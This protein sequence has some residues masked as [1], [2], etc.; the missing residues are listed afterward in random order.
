[1]SVSRHSPIRILGRTLKPFREIM[2]VRVRSSVELPNSGCFRE[3]PW[4]RKV[5]LAEYPLDGVT[6]TKLSDERSSLSI[7]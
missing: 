3:F 2:I 7:L 6:T 5:F 1:M 4:G